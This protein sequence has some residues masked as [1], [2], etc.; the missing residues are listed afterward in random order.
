MEKDKRMATAILPSGLNPTDVRRAV[1]ERYSQVGINP[2]ASYNFRVGRAFAEALG[3]P[4]LILEQLPPS[5]WESFTGVA[6]PSLIAD[7]QP[8]DRVVDLGCGG[9]LDLCLLSWMVGSRGRVVGVDFA[10][11]M[12][13]RA[14]RNLAL[15][16][17]DQA[18]VVQ[19]AADSTGLPD[20][21][22]DW[23][24]ANGILNLSPDKTGVIREIAR[25]LRPGGR[26]LLAEITLSTP[27]PPGSVQG[28][29]DWFR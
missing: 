26:F 6:A 23:V 17:L 14:Q 24:V 15:L 13:E 16:N 29:D 18:E 3:Y 22:A 12:V 11:G 10:S 27:L 2:D 21:S 9:G 28:L 5:A 8:G 25:I 7:I 19:T 1:Q 4:P 20:A